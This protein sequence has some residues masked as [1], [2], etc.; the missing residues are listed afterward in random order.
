MDSPEAAYH[1]VCAERELDRIRQDT[2]QADEETTAR[3]P[4]RRRGGQPEDGS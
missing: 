1:P 3:K 2:G 4:A